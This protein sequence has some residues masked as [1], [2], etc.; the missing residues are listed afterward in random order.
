VNPRMPKENSTVKSAKHP[1]AKIK[2][3]DTVLA[4]SYV[5][6]ESTQVLAEKIAI[7]GLGKPVRSSKSGSSSKCRFE[8]EA[9]SNIQKKKLV[10]HKAHFHNMM[11]DLARFQLSSMSLDEMEALASEIIEKLDSLQRVDSSNGCI[12]HSKEY[13]A[14]E[15]KLSTLLEAQE[16]VYHIKCIDNLL[17]SSQQCGQDKATDS[18]PKRDLQ[19]RM[20]RLIPF[21][22]CVVARVDD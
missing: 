5:Y 13:R 6:T 11:P 22:N 4:Y 15:N 10:E 3:M 18:H 17:S 20:K 21:M 1:P 16:C 7:R 12:S 2:W 14:L 19:T 9:S 8:A